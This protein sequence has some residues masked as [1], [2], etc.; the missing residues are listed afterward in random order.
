MN[1]DIVRDIEIFY[2]LQ[3]HIA[4]EVYAAL[5]KKFGND[6]KVVAFLSGVHPRKAMAFFTTLIEEQNKI[7]PTDNKLN[8]LQ[9][10]FQ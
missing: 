4:E 6:T 2:K 1:E 5:Y 10:K 9:E 8:Q 3:P 7:P